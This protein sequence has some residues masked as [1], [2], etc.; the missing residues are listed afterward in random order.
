MDSN[1]FWF[2]LSIFL[3]FLIAAYFPVAGVQFALM[4]RSL[5]VPFSC[6]GHRSR[7]GRRVVVIVCTNGENAPV[8]ETILARLR[9]YSLPIRVFVLKEEHDRFR[10]SVDEIVVPVGYRTPNQSRK[11]MRA[12]QYGIEHLASLGYSEETYVCHLDDDSVVTKPYLEHIF[13]MKEAAG[14]GVIRL[15]EFGHHTLSSHADTGR[16]FACDV[17]CRHFNSVGKP[18][19]VHGEGL[20]IRADVEQE[21]GWDFGTYGAEDLMMGQKIVRQ[22]HSFGFIPHRIFIAPPT[23]ARD[24]FLQRRRWAFSLLWSQRQIRRIRPAALYWLL[25][26]YITTWTGFVGLLIL[27]Y[28]LSPY[29]HVTLP[30]WLIAISVFNTISY[31]ASYQYG[32]GKT[33]LSLMWKQLVLQLPVAAYEGAT[34]VFGAISPP[35]SHSFDVIRKI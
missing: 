26:R 1:F 4:V 15:R 25:Y 19:E 23:S 27:P 24:F 5:L 34:V 35:N 18:M 7:P 30:W 31:F 11:K 10:Y 16:V 20:T 29:A 2:A 8:V 21:V 14:Q 22:G 13:S 33:R 9:G 3:A 12:L 28:T 17:L 6:L 32:A